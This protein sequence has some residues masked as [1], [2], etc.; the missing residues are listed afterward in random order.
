MVVQQVYFVCGLSGC[1]RGAQG[2]PGNSP[3]E[4]LGVRQSRQE[5]EEEGCAGGRSED[6]VVPL[7]GKCEGRREP[8]RG[9]SLGALGPSLGAPFQPLMQDAR[10]II[11]GK[12]QLTR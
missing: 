3:A 1:K 2:P 11:W 12:D 10:A 8:G 4:A 6:K 7:G 9:A 5:A